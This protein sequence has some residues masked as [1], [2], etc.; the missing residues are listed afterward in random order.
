MT[1]DLR[2]IATTLRVLSADIGQLKSAL[3]S[4]STA[5]PPIATKA[6][7]PESDF[8]ILVPETKVSGAYKISTK[9]STLLI[10]VQNLK[11]E[12]KKPRGSVTVRFIAQIQDYSVA[13]ASQ[14]ISKEGSFVLPIPACGLNSTIEI[15]FDGTADVLVWGI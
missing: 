4:E 8:V 11:S 15:E 9:V 10:V 3:G 2:G 5:K 13:I 1:N 14:T 12:E 6:A 7:S